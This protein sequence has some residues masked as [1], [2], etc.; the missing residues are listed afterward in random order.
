[1]QK[2][3]TLSEQFLVVHI[4]PLS[5]ALLLDFRIV[6]TVWILPLSTALLLDFRIVLT[7]WNIF[8]FHFIIAFQF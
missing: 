4:L 1:M 6:P 7:V 2:Y 5:T 8:A 3:S